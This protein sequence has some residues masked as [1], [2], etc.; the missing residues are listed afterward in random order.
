M[1]L[2]VMT[3]HISTIIQKRKAFPDFHIFRHLTKTN[4]KLELTNTRI[5][6]CYRKEYLHAVLNM[7]FLRWFLMCELLV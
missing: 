7:C 2:W 1:D 4:C 6:H 3:T 5:K